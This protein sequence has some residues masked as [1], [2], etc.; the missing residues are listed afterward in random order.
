MKY[1]TFIYMGNLIDHGGGHGT[2]GT[3]WPYI[4]DQESCL[5]ILS[6][7]TIVARLE[8]VPMAVARNSSCLTSCHYSRAFLFSLTNPFL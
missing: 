3:I 5:C 4:Y 8:L 6:T 1:K 7:E 2:W